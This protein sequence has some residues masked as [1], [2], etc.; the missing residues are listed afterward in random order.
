MVFNVL[1]YWC[2]LVFTVAVASVVVALL[3]LVAG[4][5]HYHVLAP[6]LEWFA[7]I[8]SALNAVCTST[9]GPELGILGFPA[10]VSDWS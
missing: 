6:S 9:R 1:T 2:L 5:F 10:R 8:D 4:W 7:S 3:L